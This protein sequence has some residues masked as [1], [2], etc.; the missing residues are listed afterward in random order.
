MFVNIIQCIQYV[1]F[2][3]HRLIQK[4][5]TIVIRFSPPGEPGQMIVMEF[6]PQNICDLLRGNLHY[7]PNLTKMEIK[8][9]TDRRTILNRIIMKYIREND[10]KMQDSNM[11]KGD[12][13]LYTFHETCRISQMVHGVY[14]NEDIKPTMSKE[15]A[16]FNL[17][18]YNL[19]DTIKGNRESFEFF[20]E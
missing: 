12:K 19:S 17:K 14:V 13:L 9:Y 20:G 2:L 18:K 3:F 6:I 7:S 8:E 10:A 16:E 5:N 11:S 15:A 4:N 1:F